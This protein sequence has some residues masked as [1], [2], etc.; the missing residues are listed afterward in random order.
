MTYI[1][2]PQKK[3]IIPAVLAAPAI[4]AL[5]GALSGCG[6]T[7]P[8][9]D[10]TEQSSTEQSGQ[11]QNTGEQGSGEHEEPESRLASIKKDG[12][13]TVCTTGDYAPFT[14]E[15]D[16]KF[17]G[18]DVN[19][20]GKFAENL[21]VKV[22]FVGTEW[23]SLMPDFLSKCDMAVGGISVNDERAK[24]VDFSTSLL[25]DGKTPIARCEDKDKYKSIEQ[26]NKPGVVSIM[27]EGGTNQEFAKKNYPKGTLKTHDN[28]TIFDEI[29]KGNADVMTT[30]RA[31][32][33]Y[34]DEKYP[35]L[36]ATNPDRP[37]D[38]FD[39]AFML[40]KG[41]TEFKKAVD[42]WLETSFK[43]GTYRKI[44]E[45]WVGD[46]ELSYRTEK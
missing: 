11:A 12:V 5:V 34:I 27:P 26:I 8:A 10:T 6:S 9:K 2:S 23:K 15:K 36:C 32:V 16:G 24:K 25:K 20:A 4:L 19:L 41:D 28:K 35:E 45:P 17:S 13:I 46:Q 7:G 22:E 43:D 30:D 18:I 40:P 37:F 21:D 33:L 39:K 42:D 3:K 14:V 29:V 44:E 1:T 38:Q 31:E